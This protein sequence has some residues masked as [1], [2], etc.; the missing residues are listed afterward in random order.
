MMN[1]Q[2]KNSFR[3]KIGI[4]FS[5]LQNVP[6]SVDGFLVSPS[7]NIN[8]KVWFKQ[9][10]SSKTS[11][12]SSSSSSSIRLNAASFDDFEEFSNE[13][14]SSSS[15]SNSDEDIF[16][17]LRAR[18]DY[19]SSFGTSSLSSSAETGTNKGTGSNNGFGIDQKSQKSDDEL[20]I[21]ANWKN[22]QCSSTMRVSLD[23]WIRRLAIDTYPLGTCGSANGSVYL[24]DLERGE[25][26]DCVSDIH[27]AQ[28]ADED[29]ENA[30]SKMFGKYDGGGVLAIGI[31]NDI[32]VSSGREGGLQV[33]KIDGE[34]TSYYK[35]SR[36]G[37][38]K[39]TKLHLKNEGML[40]YLVS[41]LVTSVAFDENGLLWVGSYDGFVRAFEYDDREKTLVEQSEPSFEIDVESEVLSITVNDEVGCGVA[42]TA[43]GEVILFSL[44]EGEVM[45]RW[46]PFGKG[47]GKRK[48]E[49]ARSA[50]IVQNDEADG[51]NE[52][53]WS[54]IAGGSEGSMFQRRLNVD[55]IGYVCDKNPMMNDEALVGRFRPS[56]TFS[57]VSLASPFPGLVVS[58]SQDGH[59]RVW[60]CSYHRTQDD[61]AIVVSDDG[62]DEEEEAQF[63]DISGSDRRPRCLYALTGFKVWLGSIFTNN[64]KL[65]SDGADNSIVV[66]DF[67]GE[68]DNAEDFLFEDD[69]LED[70]LDFD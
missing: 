17:S 12:T 3:I 46:K 20:Q 18:Q 8:S 52:A 10:T 64:K 48:R 69:D 15:S 35:G 70:F 33:F 47:V 21:M 65:V 59:I 29:V 14:S 54:V 38:A 19:L 53:V 60:D 66:H 56:H 44:E 36:G 49:Y 63:D 13:F 11:S 67:S 55:T 25:T 30:M 58:G 31:K 27:D 39:S 32:V 68:D 1:F 51:T 22:A 62:A 5:L 50:M 23:D 43:S 34:E 61:D 7:N 45:A 9:S 28:S 41:S 26:L 4:L 57:V 37:S 24:I 42:A 40:F 6:Q 16:A 2:K